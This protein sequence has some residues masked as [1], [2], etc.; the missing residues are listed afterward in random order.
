MKYLKD[1]EINLNNVLIMTVN[2]NIR[3]NDWDLLYPHHSVYTNTLMEIADSFNLS[4]F[5]PIS[6]IPTQD[7]D[8][9]DN[10]NLVINLM[11]LCSNSTEL[12]KHLILPDL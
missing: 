9:L 1:I 7:T 8:N 4:L 5:S 3:D 10:S 11:F 12:D 6:Q 2:F